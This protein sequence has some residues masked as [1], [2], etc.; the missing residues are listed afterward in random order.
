MKKNSKKFI[1]MLFLLILN[2]VL[3]LVVG[4]DKT[5][6]KSL[7]IHAN[8]NIMQMI[9]YIRIPKII[10]ICI[11]GAGLSA[12][13][14]VLQTVLNNPLAEPFTLGI[15][16]GAACGVI[17][18]LLFNLSSRVGFLTVPFCAFIGAII[19]M[20]IVSILSS[21]KTF[22]HHTMILSGMIVSYMFTSITLL[23]FVLSPMDTLYM[24]FNWLMGSF[25]IF[26]E[27]LIII[28]S[29]IVLSGIILL[30]LSS[31]VLNAI[32]LGTDK[33]KTFGI[34]I[35]RN[36]KFLFFVTSLITATVVSISGIIGFVGL[37][38]PNICKSIFGDNHSIIIPMSAYSGAMFLL[39][40]DTI[41]TMI[42]SP[43]ILPI[44]IITNI[45]GGIF[46]LFL[47]IQKKT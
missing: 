18:S 8:K 17:I 45:L 42:F 31:N 20:L 32:Y 19:S 43:I 36:V 7:F 29:A 6:V 27:R 30:I 28:A 12:S 46:F 41:S 15:S 11:T 22:N 44:G 37:I 24:T 47:L 34:N 38:V 39:A 26:D 1:L 16:G 35:E 14:C 4:F 3:A 23:A 5:V 33:S 10:M 2:I 13:G 40:C 9:K 25:S 21:R